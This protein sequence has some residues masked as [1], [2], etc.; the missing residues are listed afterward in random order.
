MGDATLAQKS[1][2]LD[3]AAVFERLYAL[4]DMPFAAKAEAAF[5]W[6][7]ALERAG[8]TT[9]ANEIRWQTANELLK[10]K[11]EN[12]EGYWI[13]RSLYTLAKAF[14]S[15]GRMSDARAAYELIVKNNLPP[16]ELAKKKIGAK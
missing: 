12:E 14:E 13:G 7:F 5:K 6:S 4:P 8:K 11:V 3:A 10:N 9:E 16:L 1:R 15:E 2:E